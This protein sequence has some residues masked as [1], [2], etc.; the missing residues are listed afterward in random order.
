ML[1]PHSITQWAAQL[2]YLNVG[3]QSRCC[4]GREDT[5]Q[6]KQSHWWD[7]LNQSCSAAAE[8]RQPSAAVHRT[9]PSWAW[10]GQQ[11]SLP[12]HPCA[13][14]NLGFWGTKRR[15]NACFSNCWM[16][17]PYFL[18]SQLTKAKTNVASCSASPPLFWSK[19]MSASPALTALLKI[20][21]CQQ[22]G[23][24]PLV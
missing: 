1:L 16:S 14:Q 18:H 15:F 21:Q 12:P 4:I 7:D 23:P 22:M 2:V 8:H 24:F 17:P 20:S 19:R 3:Q 6:L 5:S 10:Q 11:S 9:P 13:V